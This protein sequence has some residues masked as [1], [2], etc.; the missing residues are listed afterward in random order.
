MNETLFIRLLKY[1]LYFVFVAG[2]LGAVTL[3]FLFDFYAER[4]FGLSLSQGYRAFILPFLLGLSV[5]C[6][7]IVA[8]MIGMMRS[9]PKGPFV[10]RNTRALGRVGVL[11]LV[12][13]GAFVFKCFI[14]LTVLTMLCAFLFI[15]GGLFSFT[16]RALIRQAVLH[17]EEN[18]LTI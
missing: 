13:A 14:F 4:V 10:T 9:I 5:P 12:V 2:V 7:W 1:A 17:R 8:E 11:F 16:L 15:G 6:L 3:P 18:D